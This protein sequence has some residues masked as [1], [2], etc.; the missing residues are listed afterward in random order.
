MKKS[1]NLSIWLFLFLAFILFLFALVMIFDK[2]SFL[3][4]NLFNKEKT[5][6]YLMTKDKG[7]VEEKIVKMALFFNA[8]DSEINFLAGDYFKA[9]DDLDKAAFYYQKSIQANFFNTYETYHNLLKIYEEFDRE[10]DREVLLEFLAK[11]ITQPE[12]FPL[13]LNTLLAKNAYLIGEGYFKN[14]N[15]E[16][17]I[18]WWLQAKRA[19]PEW[20]YF[21]VELASSYWELGQKEKA[22]EVLEDCLNY[23]YPQEH[24]QQ[25]LNKEMAQFENEK[26][27]FWQEEIFKIERN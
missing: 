7:D 18:Y 21:H 6:S 13:F 4:I 14:G 27:G 3:Q 25:Y 9:Q 11:K 20:S 10:E 2:I 15:K 17:T 26:P 22:K 1:S 16:K 23:R 24:C 19:L 5:R 8:E 12:K